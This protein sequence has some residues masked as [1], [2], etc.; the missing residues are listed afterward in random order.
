MLEL[1]LVDFVRQASDICFITLS[2]CSIKQL[3]LYTWEIC[4]CITLCIVCR[5][6]SSDS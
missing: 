3:L 5:G 4:D 6:L 2:E 1:T